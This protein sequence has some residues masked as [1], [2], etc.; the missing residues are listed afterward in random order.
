MKK[1]LILF[2]FLIA[3]LTAGAQHGTFTDVRLIN[4]SSVIT[5]TVDGRFYYDTGLGQFQF[6]QG[7]SWLALGSGTAWGTI[8]GTLASQTDLQAALDL[9]A[10]LFAAAN[11][12]TASYTP[13]LG[14]AGK[15]I[16]MNVGSAN[17]FTVPLNTTVAFPLNTAMVV[18]QYGAGAT[19]IQAEGGVTLRQSS[20]VLTSPGQF[21][22]VYVVKIATNEWYVWNGTDIPS[23]NL[24]TGVT[25]ILGSTNGGAGA[26]SGLLKANGS[27]VVTAAVS[28]TDY[29]IPSGAWLSSG[30]TTIT[31]PTITGNPSF[32]G[33]VFVGPSGSLTAS[34]SLDVRAASGTIARFA[35]GSNNRVVGILAAGTLNIGGAAIQPS[36]GSTFAADATGTNLQYSATGGTTSGR[37]GHWL[38]VTSMNNVTNGG[39]STAFNV[40]GTF[41]P[42]SQNATYRHARFNYTVNQTGSATGNTFGVVIDPTYTANTGNATGIYYNPTV[43][44]VSGTHNAMELVVGNVAVTNGNLTF[45][46]AGNKITITEGSNGR[47][48]Q[49]V[50]V[51]G[52]KAITIS[53]LTTSSRAFIQL[54]TPTGVTLTTT[55]QAVCTANTLTLQANVA[56]GTI[57]A[58]DG[59]TVNY[60]VLN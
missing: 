60:W 13:V 47:V 34:T 1:I 36:Q 41:S 2:S 30:S 39:T 19:S 10:N 49:T 15:R 46:T 31:T 59:S 7:G 42:A 12:Q 33:G 32:I 8:S 24:S 40:T 55:Y 14:D 22:P 29:L 3:A 4:G 58:A 28:G 54:V 20:S 44:S 53:G 48:G 45:G 27:G 16:E 6:R 37:F 9:K 57:N 26:I 50:L 5:G 51:S 43:T 21:V 23:I 25:G 38:D 52:T 56:A 17:I 18:V 35:D 11:R